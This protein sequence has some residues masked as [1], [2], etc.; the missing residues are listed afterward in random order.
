MSN[1]LTTLLETPVR[2]LFYAIIQSV[3]RVVDSVKELLFTFTSKIRIK[4]RVK[5]SSQ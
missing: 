3:N 2:V 4:N 1:T 5:R